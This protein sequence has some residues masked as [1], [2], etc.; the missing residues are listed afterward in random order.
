MFRLTGWI[1][2]LVI[3][4]SAHLKKKKKKHL[5]LK[6]DDVCLKLMFKMTDFLRFWDT[7]FICLQI[8]SAIISGIVLYYK[9]V[10]VVCTWSWWNETFFETAISNDVNKFY[11]LRNVSVRLHCRCL[12]WV[13]WLVAWLAVWLVELRGLSS[14]LKDTSRLETCFAQQIEGDRNQNSKYTN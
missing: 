7:A 4:V 9:A 14:M 2:P 3:S 11:K 5:S 13:G 6:S 8:S 10:T 12:G 1:C